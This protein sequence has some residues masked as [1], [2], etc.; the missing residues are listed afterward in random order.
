M[1]IIFM[2][3][4]EATD[5]VKEII[6]DKE[7]YW[8]VLTDSG[9]KTVLESIEALPKKIDKVYVSPFPRT[10]ETAHFVFEKYPKADFIIEKR[11]HEINN[12]KY[13]GEKNNDDLD[14]TRQRQIA[15]DYFVR[16]GQYGEN[17][18]DIEL[19]LCEFLLDVYKN[20]FNDNTV[21]FVS[22]GSI[23]S[24]MK[25]I[26]K[27]KTPHI[28]TGK[29]EEF[30]DVDF[31]P[32]FKHI[33]LL[34]TVKSKNIKERAGQIKSLN[35]NSN[36]K[37]N[38]IKMIKKD[39]NNIEYSDDYF[40]NFIDGL[41]TKNLI[42]KKDVKFDDGVILVCFYNNFENFAKKWIEH[43]ISIGIKNFVLVNN[44]SDDNSLNILKAYAEKVNISFWNINEEYNCYKMCGWKQ[45]I[46]EF[47][48]AHHNFLIVDSDELFIYKN[49]KNIKI[50]DFLGENK[51][52]FV[53]ALMLDVYTDKKV[54][55]GTLEDF[56]FVDRGTYKISNN[57]P[58]IERF[59]G[60][61]RARIFGINPSLQKISYVSY[62]GKEV[63][64]NDHFYYPWNI[65]KKAKFFSYL[66][67]YKF[68]PGD[69]KKYDIFIKDGR[70]WNNSREYKVYNE[71]LSRNNKISFYDENVSISIN[72]IKFDF[73][74]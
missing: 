29:I 42:V 25:R 15:G 35:V 30:I 9:R 69:D 65:N 36:L 67:H 49:Y 54:F 34:K 5:N 11:L 70:H 17:K 56:N 12:G 72:D 44:N 64:A 33:K 31:T 10:I 14:E 73:K 28:K 23:T 51:L 20:N 27:I 26:L 13:S 48:G 22:H 40:S 66:L 43:Y 41:S 2:R 24:Y 3:H 60:G 45:Q 18:Y 8:S 52:S 74:D 16:F 62:T 37:E 39:F 7:I 1:N 53:K 21:M 59:Y 50:D 46:L 6:S 63:C 71:I 57:V 58:Y 19:R 4:G 55:S 47:Y 32:L 68:L 61:P 38:L